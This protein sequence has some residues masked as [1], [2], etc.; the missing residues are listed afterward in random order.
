MELNNLKIEEMMS[1]FKVYQQKT[2]FPL[3]AWEI[4]YWLHQ[5]K[6]PLC[7][8]KLYWNRDKKIARCKSKK[9]DSF[10]ITREKLKE[11]G[12]V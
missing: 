2:L 9:K 8:K 3:T 7:Q 10:I 1:R 4:Y 12:V 11:Y 5:F 6:C